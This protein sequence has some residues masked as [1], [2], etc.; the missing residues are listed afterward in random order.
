MKRIWLVAL[1]SLALCTV[2]FAQDTDYMYVLAYNAGWAAINSGNMYFGN[3]TTGGD[4]VE[5]A[6]TTVWGTAPA[7]TPYTLAANAGLHL[8]NA[9]RNV[10]NSGYLVQ[11]ALLKPGGGFAEWGDNDFAN[12]YVYGSSIAGAGTGTPVGHVIAGQLFVSSAAGDSPLG[13]Y[14]D[15]VTLTLYY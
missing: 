1:L 14:Q 12:S 9:W 13:W 15:T 7:E 10:E 4:P 8:A 11:Y 3:F 2:A 6:E 5:Y